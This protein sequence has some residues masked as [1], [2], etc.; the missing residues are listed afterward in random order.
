MRYLVLWCRDS[1]FSGDLIQEKGEVSKDASDHKSGNVS[2]HTRL[3]L[4]MTASNATTLVS[5]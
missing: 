4:M 5:Q 1:G 3:W 2:P